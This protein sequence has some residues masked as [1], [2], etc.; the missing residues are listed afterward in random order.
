[1]I[2]Y[3]LWPK[4]FPVGR[5][6]PGGSSQNLIELKYSKRKVNLTKWKSSL[7][8]FRRCSFQEKWSPSDK[9][10]NKRSFVK[11]GYKWVKVVKNG[12]K[13]KGCVIKGLALDLVNTRP[14]WY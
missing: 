8:S 1:M 10:M 11:S 3:F 5:F 9:D 6:D 2:S 7:A 4:S 13:K 12:L 14:P